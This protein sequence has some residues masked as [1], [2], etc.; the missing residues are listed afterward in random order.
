NG[1]SLLVVSIIFAVSDCLYGLR[2]AL[3]LFSFLSDILFVFLP[4][5]KVV[6]SLPYYITWLDNKE[7]YSVIIRVKGECDADVIEDHLNFELREP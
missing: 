1:F 6:T 4:N 7:S 5:A 3:G 2:L